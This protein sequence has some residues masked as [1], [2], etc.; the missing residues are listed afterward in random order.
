MAVKMARDIARIISN[1]L[2]PYVV[3]SLVVAIIAYQRS[4]GLGIWAKWTMV[5]LLSAYLFPLIYMQAR[6]AVIVRTTGAQ[7][8]LRSFFR[9]QPAEMAI[10]A[11]I[12]GIPSATILYFLGYPSDIIAT[13]VGVAAAALL[14]ALV[15]RIYR[16]SFH[17]ALFTSAVVPLTIIFGLPSLVV[18]PFILLLGASR[19]YLDEHTPLQ[20][21]T[22]FLL[23]LMVSIAVFQGFG[24]L[25]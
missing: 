25:R 5:A 6:I 24:I 4:P 7:V 2:H 8:S 14:I 13:L 20:L 17:L 18:I 21:T 15:N 16:A 23:G 10:L 19:Y 1:I 3:L 22:G 11:C 9:E 12:F